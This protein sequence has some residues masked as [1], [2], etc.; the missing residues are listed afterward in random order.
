MRT[1]VVVPRCRR[2]CRIKASLEAVVA[3]VKKC[4][5]GAGKS[6]LLSGHGTNGT[7]LLAVF[8]GGAESSMKPEMANIGIWMV[9][10][11]PDGHF[12]LRIFNDQPY[13]PE[14]KA[15]EKKAGKA[16]SKNRKAAAP[17]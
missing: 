9:E 10:E 15:A 17:L 8:L 16:A 6:I 1:V 3:L 4:F 12:E 2:L 11:Q 7:G 14:T 13:S 5:G